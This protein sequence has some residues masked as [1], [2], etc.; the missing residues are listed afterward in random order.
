[1]SNI[2]DKKLIIFDL[3]DTLYLESDYVFSGLDFVIKYFFCS[4][5]NQ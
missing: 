2:N 3:D 5:W 4:I 1:M